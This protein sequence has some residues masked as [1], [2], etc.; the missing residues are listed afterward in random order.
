MSKIDKA[1]LDFPAFHLQEFALLNG[2]K[3]RDME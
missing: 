2:I 3:L 1:L